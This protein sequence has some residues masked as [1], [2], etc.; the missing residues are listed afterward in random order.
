[1]NKQY[2]AVKEFHEKFD[3]PVQTTPTLITPARAAARAAWMREE[4]QEFIDAQNIYDQAD[5]M[6]DLMYF[7]LG[8]LVEMGVPPTPLFDIVHQAN[9]QKLWADG[10]PHYNADGKTIKPEGWQ[11][12]YPLL[13]AEIDKNL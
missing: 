5:A 9:M 10:K 12:P 3:H 11:N 7:A 8:T 1:M 6:I 4:V 2:E 13:K